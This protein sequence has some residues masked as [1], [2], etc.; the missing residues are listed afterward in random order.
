LT[1]GSVEPEEGVVRIDFDDIRLY[2]HVVEI[3]FENEE[4]KLIQPGESLKLRHFTLHNQGGKNGSE[5]G[6]KN[7]DKTVPGMSE[8]KGII[9]AKSQSSDRQRAVFELN[10]EYGYIQFAWTQVHYDCTVSFHDDLAADPLHTIDVKGT[11]P[12]SPLNYWVRYRSNEGKLVK[13][14]VFNTIDNSL[15]DFMTMKSHSIL[16]SHDKNSPPEIV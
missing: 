11:E 6:V 15:I 1:L 16:T 7:T 3:D 10:G 13:Y 9:L 2:P 14:I 8:K 5:M 12:V 4:T